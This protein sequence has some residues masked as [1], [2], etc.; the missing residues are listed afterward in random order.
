[1]GKIIAIANQKGGVTKTTSTYNISAGLALRGKKVLM[2]DLDPQASLSLSAGYNP[3]DFETSIV[4]VFEDSNKIADAIYDT[5]I[6]GLSILPSHPL[7]ASTELSLI[8]ARSRERK[9]EKALKLVEPLFDYIILD[10]PPQLSL[11]TI[12]ALTAARYIIV[13]CGTSQLDYYALTQLFD[14]LSGVK[15]DLN[16]EI[17]S[18]GILASLFDAR[19]TEDKKTLEAMKVEYEVLGVLKRATAAKKVSTGLPVVVTRPRSEVST[20]Y[21]NVVDRI[22]GKVG[23]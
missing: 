9:L 12:N 10:C 21:M 11:I 5:D 8:N 13:P 6:E 23:V 1:M 7:L 14:T 3:L 2:V 18:L 4:Q 22:I 17:E 19:A 20:E 15:E 16:S